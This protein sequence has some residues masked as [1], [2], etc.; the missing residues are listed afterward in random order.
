ML[1]F[2][3]SLCNRQNETKLSLHRVKRLQSKAQELQQHLAQTLSTKQDPAYP[4]KTSMW[5]EGSCTEMLLRLRDIQK[6]MDL[7]ITT[8]DTIKNRKI[9][10]T[11]WQAIEMSLAEISQAS[12]RCKD[13]NRMILDLTFRYHQLY[14]LGGCYGKRVDIQPLGQQKHDQLKKLKQ[15]LEESEKNIEK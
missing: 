7:N 1:D 8:I 5:F 14:I 15:D 11:N 4:N 2:C 9:D 3:E 13:A 10:H 12:N 6:D